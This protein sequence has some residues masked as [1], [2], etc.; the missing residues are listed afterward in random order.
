M[1]NMPPPPPEPP[2]RVVR[3]EA[4]PK[5][6]PGTVRRTASIV[7]PDLMDKA[8]HGGRGALAAAGHTLGIE[9]LTQ[10]CAAA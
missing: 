2:N 9:K 1:L 3:F 5:V 4:P 7:P 10:L 6:F 8:A